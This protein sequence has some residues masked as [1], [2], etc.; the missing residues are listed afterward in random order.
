MSCR[1]EG[2][3]EWESRRE[4]PFFPSPRWIE[5]EAAGSKRP[6]EGPFHVT[7]FGCEKSR[8]NV[9]K[10][11]KKK[12]SRGIAECDA[13]VQSSP[14]VCALPSALPDG[15]RSLAPHPPSLSS[16]SS[17][18][19]RECRLVFPPA[20]NAHDRSSAE[21]SVTH[22]AS[23]RLGLSL[24]RSFAAGEPRPSLNNHRWSP[25]TEPHPF[26]SRARARACCSPL[27]FVPPKTPKTRA[28]SVGFH[29]SQL[30]S[31]YCISITSWQK[32]TA[33]LIGG[34]SASAA[35]WLPFRL[36]FGA[37]P[38]S[39]LSGSWW[40]PLLLTSLGTRSSD[41]ELVALKVSLSWVLSERELP[42]ERLLTPF[43]EDCFGLFRRLSLAVLM[44]SLSLLVRLTVWFTIFLG[45]D[46][47]A[48]LPPH[49]MPSLLWVKDGSFLLKT[50]SSPFLSCGKTAFVKHVPIAKSAPRAALP[51]SAL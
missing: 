1:S 6:G 27:G 17:S 16:P 21:P 20:A 22:P 10:K 51:R 35:G 42:S 25:A 3:V 26:A 4:T 39:S 19:S 24:A 47:E 49:D 44:I 15:R 36:D 9:Y 46:N 18:C 13:G 30:V 5:R 37:L 7:S 38:R 12:F 14:L 45:A 32:D 2:E 11:K 50:T 34:F 43:N 23:L 8:L 33:L 31:T 28:R 41:P 40:D 29:Q 48:P